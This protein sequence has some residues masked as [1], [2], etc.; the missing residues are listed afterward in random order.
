VLPSIYVARNTGASDTVIQAPGFG[1][2][3]GE[4]YNVCDECEHETFPYIDPDALT[5]FVDAS[6]ANDLQTRKSTTGY[7]FVMAGAAIA[8]RKP[9]R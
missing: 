6:H 1:L 5:G 4:P 2:P 3:P 9:K 7:A 8:D